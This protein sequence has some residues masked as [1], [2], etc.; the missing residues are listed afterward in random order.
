MTIFQKIFKI[1]KALVYLLILFL[2]TQL[3]KHF[4]PDFSIVSGIRVDYLSPTLY[5]TDVLVGILFVYW[6]FR[7]VQSAN[8]KVQSYNSKFKIFNFKLQFLT[9]NFELLT[10]KSFAYLLFLLYMVISIAFLN[11]PFSSLYF[12]V[13]FLEFSFLAFY[14]AQNIKENSQ[15]KKI[16]ILLSV[17][18]IFESL[19]AFAQLVQQG[20]VGGALY[21]LGERFFTASTPG[22]ANASINGELIMRPYGTFPHPN[23]LAGYLVIALMF[24]C[25][26][27]TEKLKLRVFFFS[28][29]VVGTLALFF[30][31]SRV[32][33]VLWIILFSSLFVWKIIRQKFSL[34]KKA[35]LFSAFCFLLFA[36]AT[37][38]QPL[39]FRFSQ[40]GISEE[41]FVQREVLLD[42]SA[43][44]IG[45]NP[46]LGVGLGGF[47]PQLS[48]MQKPLSFGLYLQP[49]HNIFLLVAS[50][51]GITGFIF[52][53]GFLFITLQM[54]RKKLYLLV[55]FLTILLL[56]SFDHYFLTLQQGQLLFAMV[57]GL[58]WGKQ[59]NN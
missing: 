50:E 44:M 43:E 5:F 7:K 51:L 46:L 27:R 36:G 16:A 35:V 34:G 33:V 23:V 32:A 30:T 19:L 18:V 42:A 4:W 10:K 55:M 17:G 12:F 3:G 54:A 2:P 9:F 58:C 49:V 13:K 8:F 29:F 28:S 24:V 47:I 59:A 57:V 48:T 45:K 6:C 21:F 52:F 1:E 20:S 15:V 31:L 39:I 37:F 22:I 38:F 41:A 53:I 40:T 26:F 56:G 14:I 25:F 11:N